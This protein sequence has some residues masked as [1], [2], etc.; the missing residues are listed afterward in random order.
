MPKILTVGTEEFEFPLQGENADY[1]EQVTDWA[2]AVTDALTTV[3][4]PN[5]ILT[6]SAAINN[7]QSTFVNI[8]GFAFDTSEVIEIEASAIVT[9]STSSPAV[10][11]TENFEIR[12]N[13]N[14]T[15]WTIE[16]NSNAK[17]DSGVDF[18]ITSSGQ[19][20]YTSSNMTGSGYVGSIIFKARVFNQS[21]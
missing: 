16:I 19:V 20:Q 10:T 6:T 2:S 1:G 14:G 5:D 15:D 18:E 9:R 13:Y 21:N 11:V 7:N 8:P 12:G 17:I 3:Q 4:Q